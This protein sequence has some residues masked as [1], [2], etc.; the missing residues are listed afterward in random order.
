MIYTDIT[1]KVS[2]KLVKIDQNIYA[3]ISKNN[4][5]LTDTRGRKKVCVLENPSQV[6]TM[7]L[8]DTNRMVYGGYEMIGFVDWRKNISLWRDQ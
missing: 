2:P 7:A 6:N 8:F 1:D 3:S 4:I 5:V